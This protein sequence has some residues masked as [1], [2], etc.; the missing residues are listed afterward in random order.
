MTA[1]ASTEQQVTKSLRRI[2]ATAVF[3]LVCGAATFGLSVLVQA[4][5]AVV[6]VSSYSK[7]VEM[8][9]RKLV[10]VPTGDELS[11]TRPQGDLWSLHGDIFPSDSVRTYFHGL[12]LL[13]VAT[14]LSAG[15]VLF[16]A[17][18]SNFSARGAP[19]P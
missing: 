1:T 17:R 8:Q 16:F 9:H 15:L 12:T 6:H 7:L 14:A 19:A 13:G 4:E 2:R 3:L 11:F 5:R 18:A 10:T